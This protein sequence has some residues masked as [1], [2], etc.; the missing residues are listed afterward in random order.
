MW[1]NPYYSCV[2]SFSETRRQTLQLYM[3]TAK[4][5]Q[6]S[7]RKRKNVLC[8][9]ITAQ[10]WAICILYIWLLISILNVYLLNFMNNM[11]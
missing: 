11:G 3:N 8:V 6:Q 9:K 4:S 5:L 2:F 1:L 7:I 10:I